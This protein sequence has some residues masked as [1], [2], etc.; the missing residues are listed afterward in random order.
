ME[1]VLKEPKQGQDILKLGRQSFLKHDQQNIGFYC[2]AGPQAYEAALEASI[3][4]SKCIIKL[5]DQ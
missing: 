5:A 3:S 1:N 2:K 4:V